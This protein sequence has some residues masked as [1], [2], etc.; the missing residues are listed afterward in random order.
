M[1]VSGPTTLLATKFLSP[2][3]N[4]SRLVPRER[5]L[6]Y[7]ESDRDARL[8]LVSAPAGFGKTSL[9][10][11]WSA[12]QGRSCAWLALDNQDN[13]LIMFWRYVTASLLHS[14]ILEQT[15]VT[16]LLN[17]PQALPMIEILQR[18]VND[19]VGAELPPDLNSLLIL[20]DY[21]VITNSEIHE[22]LNYFI[23]YLPP[24]LS[25]A[26]LTRSDPPL[27]LP[28]LRARGEMLE[29][30]AADL[31][32]TSEEVEL[33]LNQVLKLDLRPAQMDVLAARTEGW[34]AGLQLAAISLKEAPD[35]GRFIQE[36]AGDD[37]YVADYLLEEVLQ[38]RSESMQRFLLNT[39]ILERFSSEL[40]DAVTGRQDSQRTLHNLEAENL[41][42]VPLDNRREWYR[43]HRL[44]ADLLHE[45]LLEQT[46]VEKIDQLYARACNWFAD[47]AY[48]REA[49]ELAQVSGQTSREVDLLNRYG[50]TFFTNSQLNLL[51]KI[52]DG[53]P[54]S[55]L[56]EQPKILLMSAWSLLAT[57]RYDEVEP[58]LLAV[59]AA[60][61]AK[62][63]ILLTGDDGDFASLDQATQSGLIEVGA[64][65]TNL[66]INSFHLD[67]IFKWGTHVLPFLTDE[68]QAHIYNAPYHLRST[69]LFMLGLA[70]KFSGQSNTSAEYFQ[71]A[72][73]QAKIV[74]NG[75]ILA[76]ATGHLVEVRIVQGQLAAARLLAASGAGLSPQA[77]PYAGILDIHLGMLD[78]EGDDLEQAEQ[79]F[80]AGIEQVRV[81]H[82]YDGLTGGYTGLAAIHLAF[83]D[84]EQAYQLMDGL[85]KILIETGGGYLLPGAVLYKVYLELKMNRLEK[86]AEWVRSSQIDQLDP[87][88]YLLEKDFMLY[89][90][91][92]M[93]Q[94]RWELALE[95]LD[96]LKNSVQQ[97]GRSG[98]LIQVLLLM[99]QAYE[100]RKNRSD[101]EEALLQAL[102]LAQSENFVRSFLDEGL[103]VAEILMRVQKHPEAGAKA[104]KLLA[105]FE[106]AADRRQFGSQD[107]QPDQSGL[108][109]PLSDRELEVLH[110]L[111]QGLTNKEIAR[112]LMIATTTVKSHT[113]SIYG[114]LDVNNR[115]QAISRARV[116]GILSG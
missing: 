108:V 29:V 68:G 41:F 64:I 6:N 37:R 82:H 56:A 23:E 45:R 25:V 40:C 74:F 95:K 10:F 77:T 105:K 70:Y 106:S 2:R 97:G 44:F 51:N 79:H 91:W 31:R 15:L 103:P 43:Y 52:I 88:P 99:A 85:E 34:V 87:V 16:D 9:I 46:E 57:G 18:L 109:E 86:V 81:W 13:D 42:L 75:H 60:L 59:E 38:Q 116:L 7:L 24:G 12:A 107:G 114:K 36:F 48:T 104:R 76:L 28:R 22:T 55:I 92:L 65:R 53:L 20:D 47:H 4:R 33:L 1:V 35:R 62:A 89:I 113:R 30:R 14:H 50:G 26:I 49:I 21:H 100:G 94:E 71:S 83:G 84:P 5:L 69:V 112:Q 78:Y 80:K 73:D 102:A 61:G 32:F 11:E 98:R 8:I 54:Q 90:R 96:L 63:E 115:T 27:N 19:L 111:E 17:A 67:Q 66:A 101:A 72:I 39:S 58:R 93:A 110:L 3:L